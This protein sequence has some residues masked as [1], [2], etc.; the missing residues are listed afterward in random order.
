MLK[1]KIDW[2]DSSWNPVT[3]CLHGCK[4]CYAKRIAERFGTLNKGEVLP[5]DEGLRFLPDSQERFYELDEPVKDHNGKTEPYPANF[6]PTL[7]KYR[8]RDFANKKSRNIFVCSMADLFGDWVPEEWIIKVFEACKAAPQHNYLFLTKNPGRY[9]ELEKEKKLIWDDNCWYGSSV[10]DPEMQYVW[11][12]EKKFHWFLSIEPILKRLGPLTDTEHLPEWVIIGAETG[13]R[14][15]KV[16]PEKAWID[17]IVTNC[18]EYGIPVF[19]K[20]S[21]REICGPDFIQEFPEPLKKKV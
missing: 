17:E 20:E 18:K 7:H 11:F 4:Y 14:K 19:M 10:T 12:S 9:L 5:E 6:F 21:L 13:N 8:L 2:A 1:T 15:E 16:V 3:G